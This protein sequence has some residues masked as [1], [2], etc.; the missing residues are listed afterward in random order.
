MEAV[1]VEQEEVSVHALAKDHVLA[2]I[3][4]SCVL[5]VAKV[6]RVLTHANIATIARVP[7][8]TRVLKQ[9]KIE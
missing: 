6:Q 3:V 5:R 7:K 8:L 1:A 9:T 4:A 2:L